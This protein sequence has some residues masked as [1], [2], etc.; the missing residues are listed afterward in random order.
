MTHMGHKRLSYSVRRA[1]SAV[2]FGRFIQR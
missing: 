2:G 1:A